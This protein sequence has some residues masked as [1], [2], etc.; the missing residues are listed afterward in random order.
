MSGT[1]K[2]AAAK[3]NAREASDADILP[4][5]GDLESPAADVRSLAASPRHERA[6][7]FLRHL[8]ATP[9]RSLLLEGG[10]A[11]ERATAALYWGL[12]LNCVSPVKGGEPC[13]ACSTCLKLLARMHRDLFFLDGTSGSIGIDE[14]RGVRATLGEAAREAAFR[15][16]ILSEAQSLTE[17]AAN[18]MLKSLEEALPATVFVLTAPQR[19]RLL[20]T[21]VSRSWVLTLAWPD[22]LVFKGPDGE[23]SGTE[24]GW[25]ET[26]VS[27]LTTGRGLFERTGA[28]GSP[29]SVDAAGAA[30]LIL[31]C[32]RAMAQ[33]MSGMTGETI[34]QGRSSAADLARF[35]ASLPE[36]RLAI[37]S[38]VLDEGQDSINAQVNAGL[39][40]D[41]V[42]TRLYLLRPKSR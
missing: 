29:G 24:Q 15:V 9:P 22:P 19:E 11:K 12:S 6:F 31:A 1:T 14:V 20:P 35:F 18:A 33:A 27:F 41:W 28:R 40:A 8:A 37:A 13:L 32:Q 3:K 16:V 38:S 30:A 7:S 10:G 34:P 5:A 23:D 25:V 21:L 26:A 39:V 4:T 2:G 17:A 36:N 42:M